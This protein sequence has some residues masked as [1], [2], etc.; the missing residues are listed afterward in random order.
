M[1]RAPNN[2]W[3]LGAQ[4]YGRRRQGIDRLLLHLGIILASLSAISAAVWYLEGESLVGPWL[5]ISPAILFLSCT[6]T[7]FRLIHADIHMVASCFVSTDLAQNLGRVKQQSPRW[8][9][10]V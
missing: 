7:A 2:E 3:I 9:I 5:W 4:I 1:M 8:S 10:A 6:G